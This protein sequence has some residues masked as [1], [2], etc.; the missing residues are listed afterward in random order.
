MRRKSQSKLTNQNRGIYT[1]ES[2]NH[3]QD[4]YPVVNE[5][6]IRKCCL[7]RIT[8]KAS[9][10][11]APVGSAYC[12]EAYVLGGV[13]SVVTLGPSAAKACQGCITVG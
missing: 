11:Y 2:S 12:A 5:E 6:C 10:A 8:S 7:P 9:E 3:T 13:V 4:R 1:M